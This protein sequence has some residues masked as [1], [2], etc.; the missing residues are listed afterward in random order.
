M[1]PKFDPILKHI[2]TMSGLKVKGQ[3]VKK[4]RRKQPEKQMKKNLQIYK[5]RHH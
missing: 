5:T 4:N 2:I 1:K 3:L